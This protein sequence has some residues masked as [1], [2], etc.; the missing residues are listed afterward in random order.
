MQRSNSMLFWLDSNGKCKNTQHI[1]CTQK[2]N[3]YIWNV[4]IFDVWGF[5]KKPLEGY[6]NGSFHRFN[7]K[8]LDT[9]WTEPKLKVHR[10]TN[11]LQGLHKVMV[12]D[13]P[14]NIIS[15]NAL[16]FEKR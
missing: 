6:H 4:I 12:K 8:P 7:W 2:H 16:P 14:W 1:F 3:P 9:L 10:F 11:N 5:W 13:F 15:W